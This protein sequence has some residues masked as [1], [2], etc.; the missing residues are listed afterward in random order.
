MLG[1]MRTPQTPPPAALEIVSLKNFP[2]R[3]KHF[4]AG[5]LVFLDDKLPQLWF[6]S[7][8]PQVGEDGVQRACV[9]YW[10]SSEKAPDLAGFVVRSA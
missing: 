10:A 8:A 6:C 1:G 4:N 9:L 3:S 2:G 7:V 5:D